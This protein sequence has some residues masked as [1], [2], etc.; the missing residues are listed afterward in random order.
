LRASEVID[1]LAAKHEKDL[2]VPECKDG[3]TWQGAPLRLDA[4]AMRRSWAN[5]CMFGY[6]V[7]VSRAD[8]LGDKKMQLYAAYCNQLYVVAPQGVV[9]PEEVPEGAGLLLV[10]SGGTGLLTKKKA[11]YREIKPP[12]DLMTYILMSRAVVARRGHYSTE[13]GDRAACWRSWLAERE[14][15]REIGHMASAALRAKYE[16]EV[17]QVRRENKRL[18]EDCE[19]LAE[20]K[21]ALDG[22]GV[23]YGKWN[24]PKESARRAAEALSAVP[25]DLLRSLKFLERNLSDT[26]STLEAMKQPPGGAS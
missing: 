11:P 8:W 16:R 20:V 2:F 3:P 17:E 18:K 24:D 14:E 4:W 9:K 22:L 26:V 12:T 13:I 10:N 5:P 23:R 19:T 7:K 21:A 1:L 6:E 15:A 25:S